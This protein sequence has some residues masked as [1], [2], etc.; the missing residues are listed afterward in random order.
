MLPNKSA[1]FLLHTTIAPA[2]RPWLLSIPVV[3]LAITR[4]VAGDDLRTLYDSHRWFELREATAGRT[5][6]PLD[7]GGVASAFNQPAAAERALKRAMARATTAV[8]ANDARGL[9]A[10]Q[11]IRAGRSAD[12]APPLQAILAAPPRRDYVPPP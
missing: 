6:D 2:V 5:V 8:Q 4:T 7:E 9:L 3:V 11:Y 1:R 12:A 10:I